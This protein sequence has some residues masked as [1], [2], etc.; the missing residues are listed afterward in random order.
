MRILTWNVQWFRGIDGRVDVARVLHH[1]LQWGE[2][3]HLI[4]L[5][6]VAQHCA[7]L[8]G[9]GCADQVAQVRACLPGY[10][11][12]YAPAVDDWRPGLAQRQRF[13]NLIATRLPVLRVHPQPLPYPADPAVPSMPRV[14][15]ALTVL[16]PWG[17]LRVGCTHLAYYSAR[18]RLA[19][20][21]ALV[22]WQQE[23]VQVANAP[24]AAGDEPPDQP[25]QSRSH[26][27]DAVLMGDFNAPPHDAAY[28]ALVEGTS[29]VWWDAWVA[30]NPGRPQPPTFRVHEAGT[31][32]VLCD[33]VFV[34]AGLRA[35]V[36]LVV[37]DE[38]T[39]LSDHQPILMELAP[40]NPI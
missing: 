7:G 18:Q 36:R 4:G 5:Q 13:G 31:T 21:Q 9:A 2:Q 20:A 32:P 19:Q 30:A 3:P 23:A 35:W 28:R 12:F 24:P 26:A 37:V 33:Y 25:F 39:T 6:E 27:V 10:E 14:L 15:A 16:A 11:V 17:A 40:P 34:T 29:P 8:D 1:A 22:A 38:D